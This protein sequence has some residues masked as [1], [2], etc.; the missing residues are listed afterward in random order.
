MAIGDVG[1]GVNWVSDNLSDFY[2]SGTP[3]NSGVATIYRVPS[4]MLLES[5]VAPDATGQ[6]TFTFS[7]ASKLTG[8]GGG[9]WN[10]YPV[11]VETK[12]SETYV[13]VSTTPGNGLPYQIVATQVGQTPGTIVLPPLSPL[14][15][16]PW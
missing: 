13:P 11:A 3:G 1:G 12:N 9:V 10:T 16:A 6:M 4:Q 7:Y 15:V 14:P 2:P 5:N 8:T